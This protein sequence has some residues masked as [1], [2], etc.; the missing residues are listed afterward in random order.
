[1]TTKNTKNGKKGEPTIEEKYKSMTDHEH[2]LKLPDTYIGGIEEDDIKMWVYDV[3]TNKM[4]NKNIKYV[5]GLFKIFDEILVHSRDQT[6]RDK[7]CT[8]IKVSIDENTGTISVWNNGEN[9]I[10]VEIHKDAECYVPEMI[11]GRI[12]TSANYEQT[13][14]IVGGNER[15]RVSFLIAP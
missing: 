3:L 4:V 5:P 1:M 12:R 2:I 13:K 6:V 8:E 7:T 10:E 9:G 11:F 15:C 14:K